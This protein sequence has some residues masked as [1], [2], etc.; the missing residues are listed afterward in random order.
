MGILLSAVDTCACRG[1]PPAPCHREGKMHTSNAAISCRIARTFFLSSCNK[2][3]PTRLASHFALAGNAGRACVRDQWQRDCS[4][5]RPT[6]VNGRAASGTG[7]EEGGAAGGK[8]TTR[9]LVL[10]VLLQACERGSQAC[11]HLRFSLPSEPAQ[12][13]CLA[14]EGAGP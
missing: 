6:A 4:R 9:D 14:L 3:Q 7:N 10:W 8:A 11:A 5:G 12:R 13:R 1:T 2:Q